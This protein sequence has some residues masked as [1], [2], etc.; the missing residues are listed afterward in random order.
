MSDDLE[1]TNRLNRLP[2]GLREIVEEFRGSTPRER[3]EL[4]LEYSQDLPDLPDYLAEKRDQLE[5]VHECQTPVFLITELEGDGVHFHLDI[6]HESP[7]VRGYAAILADGFD[8]AE[9]QAVLNSP[10]DVYNL[11]LL[12]E[13]ITP[14]RL[15]GLHALML[16]MKRQVK[17]LAA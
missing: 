13:A 3:L 6:P 5:Q 15:R 2:S 12:N 11:L 17:K 9:P 8:G 10:D 14:Q 7:T 4:L 1:L 16:Y